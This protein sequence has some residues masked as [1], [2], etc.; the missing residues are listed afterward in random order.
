MTPKDF[1]LCVR[2]HPETL[3]VTAS[4]KMRSGRCVTRQ[5]SLE[6]RLVETSVLLKT[7]DVISNNFKALERLIQRASD[8]DSG[9]TVQQ[10]YLYKNIPVSVISDFIKSFGNHPVS[11]LTESKPIIEYA[12]WL[13]GKSIDTWDVIL[14][15]LTKNT[16]DNLEISV[17]WTAHYLST[18]NCF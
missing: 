6:G 9:T 8:I 11:Q 5:V 3:I 4:N 14:I 2:S 18:K 16:D 17:V 1:G 10:G 15:S 13:K 7:P 12:E